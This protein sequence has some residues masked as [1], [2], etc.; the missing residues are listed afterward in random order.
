[1]RLLSFSILFSFC[2]AANSKTIILLTEHL[3]PYQIV[4]QRTLDQVSNDHQDSDDHQGS[5]GYQ[6]SNDKQPHVSITGSAVDVTKRIFEIANVPYKLEAYS[7]SDAYQFA[8]R[9]ADVCLFS[10]A[11]IPSRESEFKWVAQINSMQWSLYRSSKRNFVLD[12]FEDAKSYSIAA[13]KDDA[14]HHYLLSKGFEEGKNLYVLNSYDSLLH[15]LNAAS[16][17]I[18]IVLL[19]K[20]LLEYRVSDKTELQ[21]YVELLAINEIILY[22]YLA[23]NTQTDAKILKNLS[24]AF[25]K[26]YSSGEFLRI[27]AKWN[28]GTFFKWQDRRLV[29]D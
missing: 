11:R 12:S 10:T 13:I 9:K 18:D 4:E 6:K 26:L 16:R 1:M 19:N 14:S 2:F 25:T 8:Q 21:N 20:P 28:Q 24:D 7:W 22:Q 23:C 3:P 17:N 29:T 27:R 5:D 15:I